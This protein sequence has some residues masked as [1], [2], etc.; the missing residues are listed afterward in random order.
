MRPTPETSVIVM[1]SEPGGS[2]EEYLA[3]HLG[4]HDV[5]LSI[6]AF[7]AGRFTDQMQGIRFGHAGTIVE[8]NVGSP[9][10]K[11]RILRE[12]GVQVADRLSHIPELVQAALEAKG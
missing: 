4:K 11:I 2:A 10:A 9:A 5:K 7:V 12:A 8:G 1:Y 6:V 3:E